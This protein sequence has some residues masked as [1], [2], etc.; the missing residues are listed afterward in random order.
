LPAKA[1]EWAVNHPTLAISGAAGVGLLAAIAAGAY[2]LWKKVL[3]PR[4][5]KFR[6][7]KATGRHVKRDVD[8][9][10]LDELLDDPEFVQFLTDM[11][12]Q[13]EE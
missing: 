4:L 13:L 5:E 7:Q 8:D 6:K 12:T 1:K 10:Y 9:E 3:K 11:A 2:P